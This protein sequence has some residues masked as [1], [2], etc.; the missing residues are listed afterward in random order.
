MALKE[1]LKMAE[2]LAEAEFI[3]KKQPAKIKEKKLKLEEK[4]AKSK[5]KVKILEDLDIEEGERFHYNDVYSSQQLA[6]FH[7]KQY[8]TTQKDDQALIGQGSH[9]LGIQSLLQGHGH[10]LIL[11]EKVHI[12][13]DKSARINILAN[14]I[15]T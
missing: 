5:E 11:K 15:V 8:F 4:L 13:C 3:E 14:K 7:D 2:L 9:H 12:S 1:K 10:V 6:E